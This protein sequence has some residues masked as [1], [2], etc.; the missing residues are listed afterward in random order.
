MC[1]R[2]RPVCSHRRANALVVRA[3][4]SVMS[5]PRVAESTVP[6]SALAPNR[7]PPRSACARIPAKTASAANAPKAPSAELP[8]R[9]SPSSTQPAWRPSGEPSGCQE[10]E[11]PEAGAGSNSPPVVKAVPDRARWSDHL[12]RYHGVSAPN[13][14]HRNHIVPH[15]AHQGAPKPHSPTP[16]MNWMQRLKRVFH[17][18]IEHCPLRGRTLRVIACIEAPTSSTQSTPFSAP[19]RPTPYTV[20]AHHQASSRSERNRLA[21]VQPLQAPQCITMTAKCLHSVQSRTD[22]FPYRYPSAN[23][24]R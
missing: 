3:D 24:D 1:R 22:L 2:R 12:T 17:I 18:N 9:D 19:A 15:I 4:T 10:N 16:P 7:H 13:F 23:A 11:A 8:S 14:R 20:H 21:R 6:I 5:P